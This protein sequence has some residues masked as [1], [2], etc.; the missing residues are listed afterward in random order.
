[1]Y[2]IALDMYLPYFNYL[3]FWTLAPWPTS[4]SCHP[5]EWCRHTLQ[6]EYF[7]AQPS[8]GAQS[9][10]GSGTSPSTSVTGGTLQR[11]R[12]ETWSRG[13]EQNEFPCAWVAMPFHNNWKPW[14]PLM[15]SRLRCGSSWPHARRRRRSGRWSGKKEN[16]FLVVTR[17]WRIE[18]LVWDLK[19]RQILNS[20]GK[21]CCDEFWWK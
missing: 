19:M 12:L 17:Y 18:V 21:W 7:V 4:Q 8:T 3:V 13:D 1:M 5:L 15:V 2:L 6:E 16:L 20:Y 9:L 11:W 10:S 14:T